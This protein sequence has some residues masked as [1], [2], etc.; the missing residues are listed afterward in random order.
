MAFL[1]VGCVVWL[2]KRP[3]H[4]RAWP[5]G[6]VK[7]VAAL[8]LVMPRPKTG[9]IVCMVSCVCVYLCVRVRNV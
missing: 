6:I 4:L 9:L 5:H 7:N 8:V 3:R 2:E 1:C